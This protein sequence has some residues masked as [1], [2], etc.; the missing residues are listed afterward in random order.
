[1]ADA[2]PDACSGRSA[3]G[4]PRRA[5]AGSGTAHGSEDDAPGGSHT[6]SRARAKR[7]AAARGVRRASPGAA[8]SASG[9]PQA[10]RGGAA[11]RAETG[12]R[13]SKAPARRGAGSR[14]GATSACARTGPGR[15]APHG[16]LPV[17][18]TKTWVE[19]GPWLPF[20]G[21]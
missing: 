13:R 4:A 7:R 18:L 12:R 6:G 2:L 17:T 8:G 21:Q 11:S 20:R 5:V 3:A 14:S 10:P 16:V 15:E 9:S 1:M 19:R